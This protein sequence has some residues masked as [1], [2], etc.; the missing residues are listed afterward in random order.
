MLQKK[1]EKLFINL[2]PSD[3]SREIINALNSNFRKSAVSSK[4]IRILMQL[5]NAIN[6]AVK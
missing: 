2:R 1:R 6:F 3:S 5:A 4:K